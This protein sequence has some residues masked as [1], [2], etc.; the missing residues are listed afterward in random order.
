MAQIESNSPEELALLKKFV[1]TLFAASHKL[2]RGYSINFSKGAQ[3]QDAVV[4]IPTL[5]LRDSQNRAVGWLNFRLGYPL[6][7]ANIQGNKGKQAQEFYQATGQHFDE[8]LIDYLIFIS[9]AHFGKITLKRSPICFSPY[10]FGSMPR[11]LLNRLTSRYLSPSRAQ[12][13]QRIAPRH[14][15]TTKEF[16]VKTKIFGRLGR[17]THRKMPR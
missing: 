10:S 14:A 16:P 8:A 11:P 13:I 5:S 12:E 17:R 3:I 2:P 15:P 4:I 6:E 7:I 9:H 1:E